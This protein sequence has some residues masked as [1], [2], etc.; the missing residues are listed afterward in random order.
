MARRP[1]SRIS[2]VVQRGDRPA[3][4]GMLRLYSWELLLTRFGK[5]H[6]FADEDVSALDPATHAGAP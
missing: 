1:A 4:D 2:P 3:P 5:L 6:S